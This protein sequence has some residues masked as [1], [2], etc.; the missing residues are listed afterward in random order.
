MWYYWHGRLTTWI[1]RRRSLYN[2]WYH[3]YEKHT[4]Q[5][6]RANGRI[7]LGKAL[8]RCRTESD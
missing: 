4:K 6:E 5:R 2:I 3:S 1:A 8:A 7:F